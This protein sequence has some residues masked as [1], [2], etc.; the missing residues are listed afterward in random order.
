MVGGDWR[1]GVEVGRWTVLVHRVVGFG[2]RDVGGFRGPFLEVGME[3][4]DGDV[5]SLDSE[6]SRW[7]MDF[8]RGRL[9]LGVVEGGVGRISSW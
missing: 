4:V 2:Q 3:G 8:R 1:E 7:Q 5:E 9:L 6:G